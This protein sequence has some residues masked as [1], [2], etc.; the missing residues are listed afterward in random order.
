MLF[1]KKMNSLHLNPRKFF[2]HQYI[3]EAARGGHTTNSRAGEEKVGNIV[4]VHVQC[5]DMCTAISK[6]IRCCS[7][8]LLLEARVARGVPARVWRHRSVESTLTFSSRNGARE[9]WPVWTS[10]GR[11]HRETG[12]GGGRVVATARERDGALVHKP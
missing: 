2:S 7:S 8:C 5:V 6:W 4:P 1:Y 11:G 3:G 9:Q 10:Q 12:R